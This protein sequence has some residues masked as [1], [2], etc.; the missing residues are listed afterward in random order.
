[1]SRSRTVRL[2]A[3]DE[4]DLVKTFECGQC[5]RWNAG[6]DGVYSGVAMGHAARVWRDGGDILIRSDAPEAFWRDYFDLGRDYA[7]ISRGFHGGEYLDACVRYGQGIRILR[8]EPWE[9]LCSF[10]ISQCNN[11]KRIK[12]IVERLC[13]AY[14]GET[15]LA[16]GGASCR[17]GRRRPCDAALR[18]QGGVYPHG[19]TR[20]GRG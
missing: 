9:A 15:C 6:E 4:L 13:A 16:R 3:A 8:Q 12:G 7:A 5:F 19:G 10:I 17:A 20:R 18:L 2:A 11:I 14:G 1:M